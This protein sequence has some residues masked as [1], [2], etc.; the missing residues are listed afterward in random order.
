MTAEQRDCPVVIHTN[1]HR[2][3]GILILHKGE[4]LSDK[5]NVTERKFEAVHD[6]RVWALADGRLLHETPCLAVNKDH[7]I[8][9]IPKE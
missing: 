4:Q 6:A 8:L 7:V 2:I 9:M 3:E 1:H 5:L